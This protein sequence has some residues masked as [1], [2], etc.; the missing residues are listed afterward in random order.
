MEFR[1]S[2]EADLEFAAEHS[3]YPS[4]KDQPTRIDYAFT[5][6]HGDFIL[7]VGGFRMITE[8]TA[9]GWIELTEFMGPHLVATYR[10]ISEY[11]DIFCRDKKIRRLQAWVRKGFTEGMRTMRH[12]GF[13]EE[14]MMKDFL[15]EGQDA[16]MFVRYYQGEQ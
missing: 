12:L 10:V 1:E 4:D 13:D 11:M 8:T 5:L 9:W 14:Y 16:I 3:L 2:T 6:D 15:G 7:A